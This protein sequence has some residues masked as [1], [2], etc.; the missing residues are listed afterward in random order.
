MQ[1]VMSYITEAFVFRLYRITK[2]LYQILNA[3]W[4]DRLMMNLYKICYPH[5]HTN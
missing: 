4:E 3:C 1:F 5:S 2:T